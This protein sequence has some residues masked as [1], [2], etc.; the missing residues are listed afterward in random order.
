[1]RKLLGSGLWI[2]VLLIGM[3]S[4]FAVEDNGS[5]V[6]NIWHCAS[7]TN[8]FW[9]LH[10]TL[11]DSGIE[12]GLGLTTLYQVNVKGGLSTN[13]RRGRH[14]G[15]YDLEMVA[16]LEQLM[17]VE[18]GS[19]Y[20][21]GWGGW[22]DTEGIDGH[23]VGS[24]WGINALAYGNRT[25]DIVELFYEGPF[26]SDKFT[27]SFG[28]MDFTGVFDASKYADDECSQFLNASLVDDPAI[29]FP[30]QGLGVVLN[31]DV[32]DSLY[33]MAGVAD[34][35]ADSRETGFRTTFHEEDY[36]FYALEIGKTINIESDKGPM[37]GTYRIGTWIDG[38]EK[39]GLTSSNTTH[40]DIGFYT[41]CDQLLIKENSDPEDSQGLGGFFRYGWAD[42]E[43]NTITNFFSVGFQYQGLFDGRDDDI[44]GAG[45][46][47]G[48]FSNDAGADYPQDYESVVQ[49]YY[50]MTLSPR[51]I[52]SPNVQYV[53][54]PGGG[55]GTTAKD[56]I[57]MGL[58]TNFLF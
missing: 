18:G 19:I 29:P 39:S 13:N 56:A 45:Y 20:M 51:V 57:I 3:N 21:L 33:I 28:K 38:Q 24:A 43:Y 2:C 7:P 35:Q 6:I 41:S 5:E 49:A 25:L 27:V 44:L 55:T 16:D 47:R 9:G 36:L 34:A 48:F 50:N 42:S 26:F 1:M 53:S 12:V 10:D 37:N 54:N 8:G 17:G 30:S 22:P 58:R 11:E 4:V 31:Y 40:D 32:T 15:R 52:V 46:S 14:V 23:S